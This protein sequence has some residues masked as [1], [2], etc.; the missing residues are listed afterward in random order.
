MVELPAALETVE[1]EP[2]P[3]GPAVTRRPLDL[4]G[5]ETPEPEPV[6]EPVR[7]APRAPVERPA[8]VPTPPPPREPP[9]Y[10]PPPAPRAPAREWNL[11]DLERRAREQSGDAMRDEEWTALFVHLREFASADGVLPK[12]FDGLVRESFAELIRAA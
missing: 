7:A 5:L 11:W 4:P 2:A 9:A 8:P 10:Q 1:P 6:P 3:P 12:E